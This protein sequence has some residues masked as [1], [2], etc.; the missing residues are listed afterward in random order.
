MLHYTITFTQD[1]R[2]LLRLIGMFEYAGNLIGPDVNMHYEEHLGWQHQA[3]SSKKNIWV[4]SQSVRS[5][6][7]NCDEEKKRRK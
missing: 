3:M 6:G 4:P 2:D 5:S 7:M 1:D